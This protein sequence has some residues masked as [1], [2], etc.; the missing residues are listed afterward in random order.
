LLGFDSVILKTVMMWYVLLYGLCYI[1]FCLVISL[2]R[3]LDFNTTIVCSLFF[4]KFILKSFASG[5]LRKANWR[6]V[7]GSVFSCPGGIQ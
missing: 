6:D 5:V 7:Y 1:E 4:F 2:L 3:F